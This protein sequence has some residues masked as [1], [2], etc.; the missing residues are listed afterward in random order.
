M[1]IAISHQ[2]RCSTTFVS[3]VEPVDH[4]PGAIKSGP[5][6]CG[7]NGNKGHIG[8]GVSVQLIGDDLDEQ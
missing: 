7:T 5:K 4:R 2:D 3:L 8:V 6:A 1:V